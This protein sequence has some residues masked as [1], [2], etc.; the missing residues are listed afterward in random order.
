[1]EMQIVIMGAGRKTLMIYF[2]IVFNFQ[3]VHTGN[4]GPD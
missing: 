1:M 4:C 3:N 2:V